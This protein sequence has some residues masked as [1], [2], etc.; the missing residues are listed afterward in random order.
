MVRQKNADFSFFEIQ[1]HYYFKNGTGQRSK[2]KVK[3]KGQ[4]SKVKV[5]NLTEK[6]IVKV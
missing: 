6:P 3:V 1:A 2:V 5:K 4:R